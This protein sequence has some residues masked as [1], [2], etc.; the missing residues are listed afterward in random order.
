MK[1][2][3]LIRWMLA[4]A[5]LAMVFIL[6][7]V[8]QLLLLRMNWSHAT[9]ILFSTFAFILVHTLRWK[10]IVDAFSGTDKVGFLP[11]YKWM[12]HSYTLG[13]FMPKDVSLL[14]VRTYYLKQ[15]RKL[16]LSV[17]LFS[18]SF[19]R[20]LDI[21]LFLFVIVPSLLFA[22]GGLSGGG[23]LLMLVFLVGGLL[24]F[25]RWRGKETFAALAW[26][27]RKMLSLPVIRKRM[28]GQGDRSRWDDLVLGEEVL[29]YLMTWTVWA[30]LL[31]VSRFFFT[32]QSLDVN[33]SLLQCLFLI[34]VIQISGIFNITPGSLGVLE[35]GSWGALAL[36]GVPKEQILRFVVGQ[37]ILLT[38]SLLVLIVLNLLFFFVKE[39]RYGAGRKE[40][41]GERADLQ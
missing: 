5:L 6:G 38:A 15:H 1:W 32:G 39:S 29:F 18:V 19:D 4:L 14:S 33:V 23:S 16:P 24:A 28:A 30:F 26:I 13:Y 11:L 20:L 37:R 35:L 25:T 10:K 41:A 2:R 9:G 17:S 3:T 21:V 31:L 8:K 12:M 7:D 40:R 22:T 36:V 27:Y 34:P